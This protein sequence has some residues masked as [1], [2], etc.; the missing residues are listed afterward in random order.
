MKHEIYLREIG[1]DTVAM[2]LPVLPDVINYGTGEAAMAA[3]DIMDKGEV[4]IP[5]GVGLATISWES[6][7]PAPKSPNLI[8]KRGSISTPIYY[9]GRFKNWKETGAK[10]NLMVVGFPINL[11]VYLT[12]YTLK[13]TGA[14]G[15]YEYSVTF[16]EA[17]S[18]S[19]VSTKMEVPPAPTPKRPTTTTKKYTVK[20]G[21]TLWE[22]SENIFESGSEW[23][24]IYNLNKKIINEVATLKWSAAG[25]KRDSENGKW[26]FPG[27]TLLIQK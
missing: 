7:F 8:M 22:I 26:I 4:A 9:H 6:L 18:I 3:Y 23:E 15:D 27:T 17:R 2:R 10:L 11:Q 20:P 19:V 1:V 25:V 14:F 5:T 24:K 12:D 16:K 21:D 13:A